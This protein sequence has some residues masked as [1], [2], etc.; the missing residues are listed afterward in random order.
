MTGIRGKNLKAVIWDIAEGY[1]IVNPLFL[2]PIKPEVVQDLYK[3]IQHV[4]IEVRGEKFPFNDSQAIR[5]R[6]LKLQRLNSARM[7][8]RNYLRERRLPMV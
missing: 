1:T 6:N 4:L 5:L 7:I 8:I 3:E 2:K